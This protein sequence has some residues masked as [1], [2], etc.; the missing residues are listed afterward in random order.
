[1]QETSVVEIRRDQRSKRIYDVADYDVQLPDGRTV[2]WACVEGPDIVVVLAVDADKN[3]LMKREW[4]LSQKREILELVSGRIDRGEQ[5]EACAIR[6]L[7]EEIGATADNF[8]SLGKISLWNHTTVHAHMYLATGLEVGCN[9]PD[10]DEFLK[11]EKVPY[12]QVFEKALEAGTNAQTLLALY[13]ARE[14][15]QKIFSVKK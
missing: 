5:A 15:L 8:L 4:R 7:K 14:K 10:E 1:M 3:V 6:E 2:T 9:N 13:A 12:D 11:F